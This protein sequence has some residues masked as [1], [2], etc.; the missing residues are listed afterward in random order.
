MKV[1]SNTG[2]KL[3]KSVLRKSVHFVGTRF[4]YKQLHFLGLMLGFL[5]KFTFSRL[6]VPQKFLSDFANFNLKK[7]VL[8]T[9]GL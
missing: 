7:F 3:K 6:E 2:P 9:G 1:L 8:N 4:F 5:G